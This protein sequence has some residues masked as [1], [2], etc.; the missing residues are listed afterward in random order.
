[1]KIERTC[2]Y[3]RLMGDFGRLFGVNRREKQ[4]WNVVI[5]IVERHKFSISYAI[6]VAACAT[7]DSGECWW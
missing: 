3:A 5:V 2:Y 7:A 6:A 1:M 4:L